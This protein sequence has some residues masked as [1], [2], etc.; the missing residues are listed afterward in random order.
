MNNSTSTQA[1]KNKIIKAFL[2]GKIKAN[3]LPESFTYELTAKG[4]KVGYVL[5]VNMQDAKSFVNMHKQ[6]L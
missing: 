6:A 3:V 5:L 4:V 2:Q 1:S